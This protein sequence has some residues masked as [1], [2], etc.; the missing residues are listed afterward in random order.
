MDTKAWQKFKTTPNYYIPSNIKE[1][2][3]HDEQVSKSMAN[4][5]GFVYTGGQEVGTNVALNMVE[6]ATDVMFLH[7][8]VETVRYHVLNGNNDTYLYRFGFNGKM[9]FFKRYIKYNGDGACH[10]DELGYL[11]TAP[12]I[13]YFGLRLR[14]RSSEIIMKN[15]MVKMWTSFARFG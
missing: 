14:P 3:M 12:H 8:I 11:F 6:Y 10:G 13:F 1:L 2:P 5:I 4:E 15:R 9:N 7:G